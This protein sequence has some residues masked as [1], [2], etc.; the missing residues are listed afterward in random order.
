MENYWVPPYYFSPICGPNTE[1][2]EHCLPSQLF[3]LFFTQDLMD[4][5]VLKTNQ[6][7]REMISTNIESDYGQYLNE[8][9]YDVTIDEL[10]AYFG[11]ILL[12]GI[13][14]V[15]SWKEYW[16]ED[17]LTRQSTFTNTFTYI[18]WKLIT[19]FLNFGNPDKEGK[20]RLGKIWNIYT[21][22]QIINL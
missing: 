19:K 2:N 14:Q 22:L 11:I 20:C 17:P 7:A 13:V 5:I 3:G 18:R 10:K 8:I 12:S 9:W 6:N 15:K 16:S 1:Y 21:Q 4:I